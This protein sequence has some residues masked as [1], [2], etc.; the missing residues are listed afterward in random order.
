MNNYY[1]IAFDSEPKIIEL[2]LK[3]DNQK[4]SVNSTSMQNIDKSTYLYSME[5]IKERLLND[6]KISSMDT[7]IL[8]IHQTKRNGE[9][10]IKAFPLLTKNA[11]LIPSNKVKVGAAK[12]LIITFFNK[13]RKDDFKKFVD[14]Y[15]TD[16]NSHTLRNF[17]RI[18]ATIFNNPEVEE[19][20]V[21]YKDLRG[22]L[23]IITYY[24]RFKN[25]KDYQDYLFNINR[26]IVD[27]K[28]KLIEMTDSKT[29]HGQMSFS[30]VDGNLVYHNM[31]D[32]I[33]ELNI[34]DDKPIDYYEEYFVIQAEPFDNPECKKWVE[35]NTFPKDAN[36][37][38]TLNDK[39]RTGFITPFEYQ[40]IMYKR[41]VKRK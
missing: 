24:D 6:G 28:Q 17:Q 30:F 32:V 38:M 37:R 27:N 13:L 15:Y 41:N 20:Y 22:L 39:I 7:E 34:E 33:K 26:Y 18:F 10:K 23:S 2:T 21:D 3:I 14:Y 36:Q 12:E 35:D 25:L 29:V 8:V 11:Y 16:I 4:I 9:S 31:N 19:E 5:E 1:L 40:D